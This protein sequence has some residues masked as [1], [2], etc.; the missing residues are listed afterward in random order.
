MK[1]TVKVVAF[2]LVALAVADAGAQK[3]R[4][5]SRRDRPAAAAPAKTENPA[6]ETGAT[7]APAA[8]AASATPGPTASASV[9]TPATPSAPAPAAQPPPLPRA[10]APEGGGEGSQAPDA[11]SYA[12][13]LRDLEQRINELK[14]QIF[15]SKARLSLLAETVLRGTVSGSRAI[16]VHNNRMG[17]TFKLVRAVYSLDG[18]PIF[19]RTDE[20]G[21]LSERETFEI[22]NGS[23]V[24]G[25]H[26]LSVNL[27]FQGWGYGIFSYLKGY[28]FRVR[29]QHT[30]TAPEGKTVQVQIVAYEKGGPTTSLEDRP[31]IQFNQAVSSGVGGEGRGASA[32]PG[33][34][35]P[36]GAGRSTPPNP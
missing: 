17:A 11:G 29:S 34:G 24:P 2:L 10:S 8:P 28:H 35:A 31:A 14:E 36:E 13:R 27:E 4:R 5:R 20:E 1:K 25:D 22:L 23:I 18:A 26:T 16:I 32:G 7:P 19:N 15:R 9:P 21:S 6:S 3:R 12:V 33:G 30:F